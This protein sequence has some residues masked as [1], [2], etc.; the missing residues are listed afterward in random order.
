[1]LAVDGTS[2]PMDDFHVFSSFE[3]WIN[4]LDV[5]KIARLRVYPEAS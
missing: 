3:V 2:F 1:V 5:S 4:H